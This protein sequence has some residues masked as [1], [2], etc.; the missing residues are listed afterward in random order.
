MIDSVS[1]ICRH[2]LQDLL[3]PPRHRGGARHRRAVRKLDR[4]EEGALVFLR[5][6]AGGRS[7]CRKIDSHR[8][9]R[10]AQ[11]RQRGHAHDALHHPGIAIAHVVDAAQHAPQHAAAPALMAQEHR[12]Q[13]RRQCQRVDRRDQ[14]RAT[15]R[16][17]ELAEQGAGQARN[18]AD[19]HEHRQQYQRDGDDRTGDLAHRLSRRLGRRQVRPFLHH[20]L[21]VLH[22]HNGVIHHDAHCQHHGEQGH[23]VLRVAERQQGGEGADQADGNGDGGDDR[24]ARRCRGR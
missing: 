13:R 3:Y 12:A 11:Q 20:P 1:W 18:E 19:R 14:H 4:D 9:H 8:E 23:G 22:H 2:A 16:H 24:G 21:D 17:R 6:E 5:Q 15:D 7:A 10:D